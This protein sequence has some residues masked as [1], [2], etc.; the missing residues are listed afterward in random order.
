M[1]WNSFGR[2]LLFGALAGGFYP[3]WVVLTHPVLGPGRALPLYLIGIGALYVAGLAARPARRVAAGLGAGLLGTAVLVLAGSTAQVALGAALVL[4][5]CRSGWVFRAHTA[6]ACVIE[7]GLLAG[8]LAF[9]RFLAAPGLLGV[10]LGVWGFFLVQ[11][12]FFLVGGSREGSPAAGGLDPF[13]LA[14]SRALALFEED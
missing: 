3:A 14:R 6:R 8:G 12:V 1:R 2:T 9:A 4:G 10:A 11:S 13:E 7:A 5:I